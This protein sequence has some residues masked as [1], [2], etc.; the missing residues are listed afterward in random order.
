MKNTTEV[1][2]IGGGIAGVS[3][4]YHLTQM[5]WTDVMLTEKLELTAGSTWHA[6]GNLPHFSNSYNIMK[7]QQYSISLYAKLQQENEGGVSHHQTGAVR[8]AHTQDRM[9]EFE[10]VVAMGEMAGLRLEMVDTDRL[11][12]LYPHLNTEGLLGGMWDPDDGHIDPT[13]I[14]NAMASR[15]RAAGAT[16]IRQNPV[17]SIE[18][19]PNGRWKVTT[20]KGVIDAGIIVNAAGFRANE[21]AK[22]VGHQLPMCSMEHQ[23]VVT[24]NVPELEKLDHMIPM[25]RDPDVSYYLRQEG[26]GL[27]LG[28][29]E[30]GGI[31]WATDGVP[32]A[33]GQELL[34]PDLDRIEEIMCTAMEQIEMIG[35]AGIK[36]VVNGPITYT[37]DGHP[38]IGPVHGYDNYFVCTGFNFGIVQGGGAGHFMA[39]WIVDGHPELDLFELDPRRFGDYANHEYTVAKATEVYANEYQLGYANE[40]AMRPAMRDQK[41][42]PALLRQQQ[43]NAVCGAYFGWERASWFAPEGQPAKEVHSFRRGNWFE[44]V[45]EE[46]RLVQEKAGV[47][48]LSPF[49]KFEISGDGAYNWL[50]SISPNQTPQDVGAIT[51]SHPLSRNGG[52]AWEYSITKLADQHY[53][54]MAP[55]AAE[56]LVED[57]LRQRLPADNS[58][59]LNNITRDYGTLVLAGPEARRILSKLTD[60]PL[61][62][63][64]FPWF[65]GQ[66]IEVAG[67]P[68]RALR[69]NFVGELGWELHHPIEHQLALYDALMEAG[70]AHGI[71]DFGLRAMDSLRLEKGYPMWGHDLNLEFNSREANLSYFVKTEGREFE[72]KAALQESRGD[73]EHRLVLLSVDSTDVDA[74]TGMEPVYCNGEIV[75]QVSSGGYGHRIQQSLAL[76]YVRRSVLDAELSVKVL[77]NTYPARRIKGCAY[78][79]SNARLKA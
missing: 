52:I 77:G 22:M 48:D 58:V 33:F 61:D 36:T 65:T 43:K 76:A 23:F 49:T 44:A 78:D 40:Y 51:L 29:Y 8:L 6:A 62:N 63:D 2:I 55:A 5:G 25:L 41:T 60:T 28:P 18:Q 20:A 24:D 26:K 17:E 59:Q 35:T 73:D 70:A 71:G 42:V 7:L 72:G 14:T 66:Q 19:Q 37:P 57:W 3:T 64:S 11:K 68:V 4:L 30:P 27:I 74:S 12:E 79:P 47:I 54:I 16:I 50:E 10:R 9:D 34:A 1:L 75:G 45:A 21:V 13:T 56:L 38:L 46:C 39:Q 67:V 53:Y 32:A 69:M 31:P 15:A